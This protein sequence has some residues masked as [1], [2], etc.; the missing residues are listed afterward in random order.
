M[1]YNHEHAQYKEKIGIE[2]NGQMTEMYQI[3]NHIESFA[4]SK[5]VLKDGLDN[6]LEIKGWKRY[7][8]FEIRELTATDGFQFHQNQKSLQ[9]K[10]Y[11]QK[12]IL[13]EEI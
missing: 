8:S 9:P 12:P 10:K 1:P 6:L 4:D 7:F 3:N 13:L 11:A 5:I 2:N